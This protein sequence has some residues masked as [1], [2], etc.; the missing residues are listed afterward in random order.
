MRTLDR[1]LARSF[2]APML[3]SLT[4]L[5]GLYMVGHAFSNLAP[6]I[7]NADNIGQALGRMAYVYALR[8][9]FFLSPMVPISMLIGAAFGIANLSAKNE[10]LAMRACGIGLVRVLAPIYALAVLIAFLSMAN[11]EYLIPKV[12]GM[13]YRDMSRWTGKDDFE[14]VSLFPKGTK[15]TITMS[16]SPSQRRARAFT[17]TDSESESAYIKANS[18]TYEDGAWVLMDESVTP[19][20]VIQRWR[21]PVTPEDVELQARLNNM[22]RAG[23]F[24]LKDI[25]KLMEGSPNNPKYILNYHTRL[26]EPFIGIVLVAIGLPFVIGNER[27]RGSRILGVGLCIGVCAVFYLVQFVTSDLAK[28]GNL[29]PQL[30]AWLPIAIFAALGFYLLEA[31]DT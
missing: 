25:R 20:K 12:E 3:L 31:V 24:S 27:I 18:A 13:T 16:Y 28:S 2:L 30:A 14:L 22:N 23:E 7:N 21:G 11:R 15:L 8:V 5:T 26:A 29:M 1:Y 19:P 6:F 17:I 10:L 9:P 4:A